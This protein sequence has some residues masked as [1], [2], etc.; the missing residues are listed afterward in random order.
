LFSLNSGQFRNA[1]TR[2]T[3][4]DAKKSVDSKGLWR[5][6]AQILAW[7]VKKKKSVA[8]IKIMKQYGQFRHALKA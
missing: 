5:V 8:N 6:H 1:H 3:N 7:M 2:T 4:A